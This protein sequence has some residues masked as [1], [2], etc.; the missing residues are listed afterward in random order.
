MRRIAAEHMYNAV[1]MHC[2]DTLDWTPLGA[3]GCTIGALHHRC[4]SRD[5]GLASPLAAKHGH[6]PPC[7]NEGLV[8]PGSPTR[9]RGATRPSLPLRVP[10]GPTGAAL[11]RDTHVVFGTRRA[12]SHQ[13]STA[14]R[15]QSQCSMYCMHL[16]PIRARTRFPGCARRRP[17]SALFDRPP[18]PIAVRY[19]NG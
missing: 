7:L 17:G 9:A 2:T 8:T 3:S 15:S 13:A 14:P 1:C 11:Q 4:G 12:A 5:V 16:G 10:S 19:S 18:F 6:W